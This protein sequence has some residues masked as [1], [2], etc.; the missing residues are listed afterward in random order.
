MESTALE[1]LVLRRVYAVAPEKVWRAWFDADALRSWLGQADFPGWHAEADARV[2]GAFRWVMQEPGGH[3][4]EAHGQYREL[5]PNRR[6]AFTWRW[7]PGFEALI[8]VEL[9]AVGSGTEM[10][11]TLDAVA[12]PREP[13][14]WRADFKRLGRLLEE[15]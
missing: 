12:D 6:L 11:F 10:V 15:K 2:G 5:V 9:Q 1:T 13:D 3:V 7:M 4:Y 14:A 8:T